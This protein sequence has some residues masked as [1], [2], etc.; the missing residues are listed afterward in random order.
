VEEKFSMNAMVAAYLGA[1]DQL[2]RHSGTAA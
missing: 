2:L 1:Y